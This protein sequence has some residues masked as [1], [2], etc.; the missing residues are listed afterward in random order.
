MV[1]RTFNRSERVSLYLAAGGKCEMCG[2]DLE[3]GWHGDHVLPYSKGGATIIEN[4]QALCP[5]CNRKKGNQVVRPVIV[6]PNDRPLY[7]WQDRALMRV[8]KYIN[9]KRREFLAV[10]GPG[11]GKTLFALRVIVEWLQAHPT[12]RIAVIVPSA[13]LKYQWANQA[14]SVGLQFH[15]E[16]D[17]NGNPLPREYHGAVVTYQQVASCPQWHSAFVDNNTLVV[18]DE[19]HHAGD[20][21]NLAW[22]PA[23]K[24]AYDQ[25]G[26]VLVLSGTPF[27][28]DGNRIPFVQYDKVVQPGAIGYKSIFDFHYSYAEGLV[29]ETVCPVIFQHIDGRAAWH[30]DG[31]ESS[32]TLANPALSD[33]DRS[34]ALRAALDPW[35]DNCQWFRDAFQQAH[36]CLLEQ[37][38][39]TENT[40]AGGLVIAASIEHARAYADIIEH[41][42]GTAPLIVTSEDDNAQDTIDD[43]A[44]GSDMWLVSVRMVSEGVDIP[45]L[46]VLLYATNIREQLFF[47]QALG[48]ILRRKP[49]V[50]E[51][52]GG[53][54]CEACDGSGVLPKPILS[55]MFMPEIEPLTAYALRIKETVEH[56]LE[57]RAQKEMSERETGLESAKRVFATIMSEGKLSGF[58]SDG[59]AFAFDYLAKADRLRKRLDEAGLGKRLSRQELALFVRIVEGEQ[60]TSVAVHQTITPAITPM[61]K[62]EQTNKDIL[63]QYKREVCKKFFNGDT[64]SGKRA[65]NTYFK[66]ALG[67]SRWGVEGQQRQMGEM[68]EWL[69]A[70]IPAQ[71][72]SIYEWCHRQDNERTG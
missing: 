57:E 20:S 32:S 3:P 28:S 52:C 33:I 21:E 6:W 8:Q 70:D 67:E 55:Y 41:T 71:L 14:A 1:K 5:E 13:R 50:C 2:V 40:R 37:R 27:R 64:R 59:I 4:G 63:D 11:S 18:C 47:E 24:D 42:T 7:N 43:F 65:I 15:P 72:W 25:A 56:Y 54:G 10:A 51:I 53:R 31:V 39:I 48:R 69:N 16:W 60:E 12:G 62:R 26:F 35:N 29:D 36:E 45:R 17:N 46:Q 66:Q 19:I 44:N 61:Y 68:R 30:F 58:T 9:D 49:T 22:G 23:L 38:E 34:F